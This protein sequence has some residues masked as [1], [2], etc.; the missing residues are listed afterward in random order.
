VSHLFIVVLVG[1][2]LISKWR[3]WRDD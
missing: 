1:N 2:N 3:E